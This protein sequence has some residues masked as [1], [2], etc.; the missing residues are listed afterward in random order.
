MVHLSVDQQ[1]NSSDFPISWLQVL[2]PI[3][4]SQ[5]HQ[6]IRHHLHAIVP[7]LDAFKAEQQPLACV[8]PRIGPL[9]APAS[10][11]DRGVEPPLAPTLGGFTMPRI[12]CDVGDHTRVEDHLPIAR[13]I[14]AAVE[15]DILMSPWLDRRTCTPCRRER[16]RAACHPLSSLRAGP[17]QPCEVLARFGSSPQYSRARI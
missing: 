8:L 16:M 10:R 15:G 6:R 5:V 2:D 1:Q 11:M 3:E 14:K 9:D 4:R 17:P 7:L 12:L 13:G